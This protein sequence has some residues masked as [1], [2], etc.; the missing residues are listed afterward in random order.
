M[1]KMKFGLY[2]ILLIL[3]MVF[4]LGCQSDDEAEETAATEATTGGGGGSDELSILG[5]VA[6]GAP[7]VGFVAAKDSTGT[8]ETADI[9]EGGQYK[10][11]VKNLTSPYLLYANGIASGKAYSI[12]SAATSAD[13]NG[14]VNVTPLTDLIVANVGGSDPMEFFNGPTSNFDLLTTANLTA[15]E[16]ILRTRLSPLINTF[17]EAAN[18]STSNFNLLN[19]PFTTNQTG[20]DGALDFIEITIDPDTD[21]AT[22]VNTLDTTQ[23]TD[24]LTPNDVYEY[25]IVAD[26]ANITEVLDVYDEVKTVFSNFSQLLLDGVPTDTE[27][28]DYIDPEFRTPYDTRDIIIAWLSS[29]DS[30][31]RQY[32]IDLA[33]AL[34]DKVSIVSI[35]FAEDGTTPEVL[36]QLGGE[37][38]FSGDDIWVLLKKDIGDGQGLKWRFAGSQKEWQV[39]VNTET[40]VSNSDDYRRSDL[41]FGFEFTPNETP[42]DDNDYFIVTGPGLPA[43]GIVLV[44]RPFNNLLNDMSPGSCNV[45]SYRG[46]TDAAID[47][48]VD[49]AT[50]NFTRYRDQSNDTTFA[51]DSTTSVITLASLSEDDTPVTS[52]YSH[53]GDPLVLAK[54]PINSTETFDRVTITSPTQ[55]VL[56][57]FVSGSLNVAWSRPAGTLLSMVGFDRNYSSGEYYRDAEVNTDSET[58]TAATLSVPVEAKNI[59]SYR[60]GIVVFAKDSYGRTIGTMLQS[61]VKKE[62]EGTWIDACRQGDDPNDPSYFTTTLEVINSNATWTRKHYDGDSTC[63]NETL[64]NDDF[65]VSMNIV[66]GDS[67]TAS[68]GTTPV[69]E[70]DMT[71]SK[72]EAAAFELAD[73]WSDTTGDGAY[74][75]YDWVVGTWYDVT[76]CMAD[77]DFFVLDGSAVKRTYYLNGTSL[78]FSGGFFKG[79]TSATNSDGRYIELETNTYVKQ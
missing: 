6:A 29:I 38:P 21:T 61:E 39:S 10:L 3:V 12:L 1:K 76:A 50:Y 37:A 66:T 34:V 14:T 20:L 73:E 78:T 5:T 68:D 31:D 2:F 25:P 67:T 53:T 59:G 55:A 19:T 70:W 71:M 24:D 69:R 63:T 16:E 51:Q 72:T 32:A 35:G 15:Q 48:I 57:W 27:L 40:L 58:A 52:T 30:E 8:V 60:D 36:W 79:D 42:E 43:E 75:R 23:I 33:N 4:T 17:L 47:A 18:I 26:S 13:V 45:G 11:S 7:M 62:L 49:G 22:I 46:L 9:G 56:D 77:N 28:A 65:R 41:A 44:Q 74:C 64:H 54:R